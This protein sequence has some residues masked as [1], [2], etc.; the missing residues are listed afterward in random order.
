MIA[1][2]AKDGGESKVKE[3]IS[4]YELPSMQL[5]ANEEGRKKSITIEGI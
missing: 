1:E 3:G 4:V 5:L 2:T